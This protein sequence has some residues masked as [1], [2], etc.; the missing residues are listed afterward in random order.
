MG[1]IGFIIIAIAALL[2]TSSAINATLYSTARVSYIVAK[3]GELPEIMEKKIWKK[4]LEGLLITAGVSLLLANILDVSSISVMGSAGF[5]LIFTAVN[6]VNF[7]KHKE[8]D[9]NRWISLIGAI[10]CLVAF[11]AL[12]WHG[13]SN[14]TD[15]FVL[16]AMIG[17]SFLFEALYRTFTS[18][19]AIRLKD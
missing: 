5:L 2:S 15:L 19:K 9:S 18:R 12:I 16:A 8:T 6:Y 3:D 11:A 10:V 4:P 17:G 7:R 1:H 14:M 13:E